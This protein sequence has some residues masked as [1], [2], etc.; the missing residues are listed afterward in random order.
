ME[1]NKLSSLL[2]ED[3]ADFASWV[4]FITE[5]EETS[6]VRASSAIL[7]MIKTM[8]SSLFQILGYVLNTSR[9]IIFRLVHRIF[10]KPCYLLR[11]LFYFYF[12][13]LVGLNGPLCS[14]YYFIYLQVNYAVFHTKFIHC[15]YFII[16][17]R[18]FSFVFNAGCH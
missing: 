9:V 7:F 11:L 14:V 4:A 17:N 3:K 6:Y 16:P 15:L 12:F 5:V 2:K 1:N 13:S 10:F 8:Y 18:L